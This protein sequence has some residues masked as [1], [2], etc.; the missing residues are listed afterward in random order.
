MTVDALTRESIQPYILAGGLSTRFGAD[1]CMVEY[2][3]KTHIEKLYNEVT[4]DVG[5]QP[6]I[7]RR[8][9]TDS[10]LQHYPFVADEVESKGPL[11]GVATGLIDLHH[12]AALHS[13]SK[14]WALFITCDHFSW[15]RGTL[16]KLLGDNQTF[17]ISNTAVAFE[18]NGELQP[19]P[20]LIHTSQAE[21]ARSMASSHQRSA[22]AFLTS[23]EL[24]R[25]S[26]TQDT[27]LGSFN[28][29]DEFLRLQQSSEL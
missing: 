8:H 5:C 1:K 25:V 21:L 16:D 29:K 13:V 28:T 9:Q 23:C 15:Q 7:V 6:I 24:K 18:V 19:F 14:T 3:G 2:S 11:C 20:C 10:P 12:K 22:K 26:I 27:C 4:A 17:L